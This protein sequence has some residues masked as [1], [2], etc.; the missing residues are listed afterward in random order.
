MTSAMIIGHVARLAIG[1]ASAL[2][3]TGGSSWAVPKSATSASPVREGGMAEGTTPQDQVAQRLRQL[4]VF[5]DLL[6]DLVQ[7]R[8]SS[9]VNTTI[10]LRRNGAGEI[11]FMN[12]DPVVIK[13]GRPRRSHGYY[14]AGHGLMFS[15]ETPQVAILPRSFD[16]RLSA[17]MAV[18]GTNIGPG[19]D[20]KPIPLGLIDMRA[21]MLMRS[22]GNLRLLLMERDA[23]AI[24][25]EAVHELSKFETVLEEIRLS[26]K[27]ST[28]GTELSQEAALD[29]E[30]E[31]SAE[32]RRPDRRPSPHPSLRDSHAYFRGAIER[33][34]TLKKILELD[35]QQI[36]NTV[37]K[38]AIEALAQFGTVLRG[39]ESNDQVS[40]M[41]LPPNLWMPPRR[42]G[43]SV[44]HTGYVISI[45]Y[46]DIRDFSNERINIKKFRERVEIRDRLGNKLEGKTEDR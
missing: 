40:I 18:L 26:L 10:D 1:A 41:V 46:K 43:V 31:L 33:Q 30:Q 29:Q 17:P 11:N 37:I 6:N 23:A 3:L 14:L 35:D 25:A 9:R 5:E 28:K 4:E 32:A 21:D 44:N 8:V 27:P 12:L 16:D 13:V 22:V 39:L 36:A 34:H 24:E 2:L 42:N 45:R 20:K 19:S 15:I 38:A 7:E